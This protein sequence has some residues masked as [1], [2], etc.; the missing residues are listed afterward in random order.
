MVA[1]FYCT[2][3]YGLP[4]ACTSA[5]FPRLGEPRSTVI[6]GEG[7]VRFGPV[8]AIKGGLDAGLKLDEFSVQITQLGILKL[9]PRTSTKMKDQ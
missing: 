7:I 3:S 1:L 9:G 6:K 4:L 2:K 8:T 5:D